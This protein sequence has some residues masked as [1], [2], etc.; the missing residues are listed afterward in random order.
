MKRVF[1]ILIAALILF[2]S[3][4]NKSFEDS[5]YKMVSE[6][7]ASPSPSI[8]GRTSG[9]LDSSL[10]AAADNTPITNR[11]RIMNAYL[12]ITV[13]KVDTAERELSKKTIDQGG[14]VVSSELYSGSINLVVKI[15][16]D[17]FEKFLSNSENLGNVNSRSISTDDVTESY[18]DIENRIKNKS[19]LRDRFREYLKKADTIEDIMSVERQLNDVTT[20]IEQLEGSFRGLNRDIDYS[21]VSFS[22]T[23]P[24]GEIV[25]NK[26]PS[27]YKAFST[28]GYK[29]LS[30]LY[31]LLFTVIYLFIF[32]IPIVLIL[33]L[34]Y[35]LGWGKIG[36]IR[37]FFRRLRK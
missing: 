3:C 18:Y 36:L 29:V 15:P 26:I 7:V 17:K 12:E 10:N 23:P 30:F 13:D 4:S 35:V 8:A 2:I 5:N 11:K 21:T 34:L 37:R 22:L 27:F 24:A 19:I 20:E 16:A 1:F 6:S 33:G 32:G 28:L 31:Y 9:N 14:W 25:S